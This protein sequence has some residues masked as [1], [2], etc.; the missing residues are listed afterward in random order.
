V[1]SPFAPAIIFNVT[2]DDHIVWAITDRYEIMITDPQGRLERKI[3]RDYVPV[4]VTEAEKQDIIKSQGPPDPEARIP[5]VYPPF[6][7]EFPTSDEAGR[8]FLKTYERASAGVGFF[9]DAFDASGRY[10]ARIPL[11]Q[12]ARVP[13]V[14]KS[15]RLY[16]IEEDENGYHVVKRYKVRI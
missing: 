12:V 10:L 8:I 14:W 15:G 7:H 16:T 3:S 9:F 4:K 5:N 6:Q 13:P 1:Y 2:R 11:K